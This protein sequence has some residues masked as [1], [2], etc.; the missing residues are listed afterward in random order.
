MVTEEAE[1]GAAA[2]GVQ[3]AWKALRRLSMPGLDALAAGRDGEG[4]RSTPPPPGSTGL[5][6][7]LK[8]EGNRRPMDGTA[9]AIDGRIQAEPRRRHRCDQRA[10]A[11]FGLA[12]VCAG[13]L[14]ASPFWRIALRK[15]AAILNEQFSR[16]GALQVAGE[17]L[18]PAGWAGREARGRA[19]VS[20]LRLSHSMPPARNGCWAPGR[21]FWRLTL[22]MISPA[23]ERPFPNVF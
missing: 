1:V 14:G 15:L 12:V 10:E 6:S 23:R 13:W 16:Y 21:S 7:P 22:Q 5:P 19:I 9:A 8:L 11:V 18:M 20:L 17:F 4:S 2:T 3:Q